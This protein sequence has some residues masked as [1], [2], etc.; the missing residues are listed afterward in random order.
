MIITYSS[1]FDKISA[2]DLPLIPYPQKV[3]IKSG[4]FEIP[5]TISIHH[6]F[7]KRKNDKI[8]FTFN[9]FNKANIIFI[10]NS[11]KN[12]QITFGLLPPKIEERHQD[13]YVI[14]IFPKDKPD[15]FA[16]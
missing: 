4:Y 16:F 13:F 3:E 6:S 2:Q 15:N 5:K 10:K 11:K 8:S 12:S 1:F 7:S 14:K 9:L